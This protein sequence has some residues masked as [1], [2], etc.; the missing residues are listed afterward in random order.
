MGIIIVQKGQSERGGRRICKQTRDP[1]N[2]P[3]SAEYRTEFLT[4]LAE[5]R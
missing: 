4:L 3:V 1:K 5:D 2:F